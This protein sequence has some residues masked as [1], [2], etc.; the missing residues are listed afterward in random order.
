MKPDKSPLTFIIIICR[1]KVNLQAA[2]YYKIKRACFPKRIVCSQSIR[3]LLCLSKTIDKDKAWVSLY[4]NFAMN[5][6]VLPFLLFKLK[7][8]VASE[9]AL[10]ILNPQVGQRI[11]RSFRLSASTLDRSNL[12]CISGATW[13]CNLI[14]KPLPDLIHWKCTQGYCDTQIAPYL[15]IW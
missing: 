14:V 2:P 13:V 15:S 1:P 8:P 9:K 3:L 12:F 4:R 11:S 5:I 6:Q 7:C 10:C